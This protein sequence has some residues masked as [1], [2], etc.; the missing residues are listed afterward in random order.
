MADN[1]PIEDAHQFLPTLFPTLVIGLGGTGV[2]V[3]RKLRRRL[4][5]EFGSGPNQ[6]PEL[7]QLLGVDTVPLTNPSAIE[8]LRH[9]EY[10]YMGGFSASRVIQ[11]LDRFPEIKEWWDYDK[12]MLPGGYISTGARQMRIIG[13]IAFFRRFHTYKSRLK[14]KLKRLG[15]I[16]AHQRAHADE[17]PTPMEVH[18]PLIFIVTSLCGGTGAG[19]FLD[20]AHHLRSQL[21]FLEKA[22]IIGILVMPSVFEHDIAALLQRRR[23]KANAYAALKELDW[24]QDGHE[25][26]VRYPGEAPITIPGRPFDFVYLVDLSNEK[27]FS[28]R[29]QFDA[30]ELIAHF[31]FQSSVSPMARYIW[32][33]DVNVSYEKTIVLRAYPN[34]PAAR[35]AISA[36]AKCRKAM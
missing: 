29:N 25:F 5:A 16:A 28:L 13:R 20:V 22:K 9:H 23:I 26:T 1:T 31:I 14:P 18:L 2:E 35:K 19:M 30:Q 27:G 36:Q 24:F 8:A 17:R 15:D 34:N 4:R 21:E 7:V 33:R 32:E 12:D 6:E 3:L 11:N 10:A